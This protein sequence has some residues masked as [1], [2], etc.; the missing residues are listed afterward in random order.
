MTFGKKL[1]EL[2]LENNLTQTQLGQLLNVSKANISKYENNQLEPNLDTL[3]KISEEFNVSIDYLIGTDI[4]NVKRGI[5]EKEKDIDEELEELLDKLASSGTGLMFKGKALS[6][7]TK[8]ALL[9]SLKNT[10]ALADKMAEM[11]KKKN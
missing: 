6:D 4:T 7:T 10:L 8:E 1:K 5:S 3:N 2:R 11:D 9:M